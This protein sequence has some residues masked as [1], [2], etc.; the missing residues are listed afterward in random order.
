MKK[1]IYI[2]AL[3]LGLT[4]TSLSAHSG[5][6][7]T[8]GD[9]QGSVVVNTTRLQ[10][11]EQSLLVEMSVWVNGEATMRYAALHLTPKLVSAE[12]T[13][14]LP[15]IFIV[16][17][18]KRKV[19]NRWLKTLSQKQEKQ[20]KA[21]EIFL[22]IS[23][24]SDTTLSYRV[25]V[26][27]EQ[28]MDGAVLVLEQELIG[29]RDER[30]LLVSSLGGAVELEQREPYVVKPKVSWIVPPAEPKRR[31]KQAEA[32]LDFRTG[33]S[34]IEPNYRR[35]PEELAKIESTLSELQNNTDVTVNGLFVE[36]YASPEGSYG[37]NKRLSSERALAL[38]SYIAENFDLPFSISN[39]ETN[40]V[41]E[42]WEGLRSLVTE[43]QLANKENILKIIDSDQAPD[44][45]EAQ[46]KLLGKTYNTLLREFF[47]L[48]RRVEYQIDYM[49]KDYT[50]TEAKELI[51]RREEL[52]SHRE[53]FDVALSYGVSNREFERI[54][55]YTIPNYF[56]DDRVAILNSLAVMIDR[57]ETET[58]KQL[59]KRDG[60]WAES[61]NNL[62]V[63]ALL[64]GRLDEAEALFREA[65]AGGVEEAEHNLRELEKK[66]EDNVRI[67]R[68]RRD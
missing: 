49:V 4:C 25:V 21:P 56:P 42:D 20:Y 50:L 51:G 66:K 67:E 38:R 30:Y 12:Q 5:Y 36:G 44:T 15:D 55:L 45:K 41:A 60:D 8:F 1:L 13:E 52:L 2:I 27:Y 24:K 65:L 10:E 22:P 39:I 14:V 35:N 62:G 64:E 61:L 17:K 68:R 54:V 26:P 7:F 58:A 3:I 59:L 6:D 47:P 11:I 23:S 9:Y 28:W 29:Y 40:S 19:R 31:K 53:L 46:L 48:L 34:T 18:N 57:G 33:R 16:G 32:Y 43:S 63:I 37:L